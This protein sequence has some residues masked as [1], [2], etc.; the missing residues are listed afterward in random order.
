MIDKLFR[1]AALSRSSPRIRYSNPEV[2][3]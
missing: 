2:T 3:P 1:A